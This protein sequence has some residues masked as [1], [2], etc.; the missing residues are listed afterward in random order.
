[1]IPPT[2]RFIWFGSRFPWVNLLALRSAQQRGG[3]ERVVLH[4]DDR[5]D[6]AT[7]A[8][9]ADE[10]GVT[11][12][13]IE[14][15]ELWPRIP[16]GARLEPRF[17][18]LDKANARANVVRAA[19]LYL[20]GG[21]YLDMDTVTV[22][23]LSPLREAPAFCGAEHVAWPGVVRHGGSFAAKALALGRDLTRAACAALPNGWALFR[24]VESSYP[25]AANNAVL[26]A[27][28][29]SRFL[30]RLLEGM[31]AVPE[32]RFTRPFALG[33]HLLQERLRTEPE[34]VVH[35]PAAF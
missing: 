33:T 20:E 19:I 23:S 16:A 5:L 26:G 11:L 24:R 8:R 30:G 3:F 14:L 13:P 35:P 27:E 4:H 21:V 25:R 31:A 10:P 22:R 7:R 9:L 12:E 17:A 1:M 29:G 34:V 18:R 6:G 15:S 32:D 2:A 28:A